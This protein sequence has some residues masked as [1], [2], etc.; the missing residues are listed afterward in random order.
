M[1]IPQL[2]YPDNQALGVEGQLADGGAD[3]F[4]VTRVNIGA[5][6]FFGQAV[7]EVLADDNQ[8][9]TPA[10]GSS[11]VF[12]GVTHHTHAIDAFDLGDGT[13]IPE[14][15]P[16]N[17]MQRGR[18]L[19]V[20]EGTV[21]KA[22]AAFYR[23][24]NAGALPEKVGRFRANIDGVAQVTT[25][26]PT[27]VNDIQYQMTVRFP[28]VPD[29]SLAETYVFEVLGDGDATATEINDDFRTQMAADGDFTARM[30]A[31]GTATLIL[32][33][34]QAGVSA[35]VDDTGPGVLGVVFTTPATTDARRAG[36][37]KFATGGAASDLVIL[38]V[39]L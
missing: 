15:N 29:V 1:T 2:T 37:S 34:Q 14:D 25:I 28:A 36:R 22:D 33:S 6:M 24:Q 31:T 26:T 23:Y 39:A 11:A 5:A 32:T 9:E 13:G 35:E 4:T 3:R 12:A 8:C 10:I 38:D 7:E 18:V 16:A 27:A 21:V 20:A 30:V 17:V 19:V